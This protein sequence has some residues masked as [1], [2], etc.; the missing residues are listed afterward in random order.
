MSTEIDNELY[1]FRNELIF[2][3]F[4][5]EQ[6]KKTLG[7]CVRK[8]YKKDQFVFEEGDSSQNLYMIL[9]GY[10]NIYKWDKDHTSQLLICSIRQGKFFGEISF[11]SGLPRNASAKA[12]QPAEILVL[13]KE[14]LS[15]LPD[16]EKKMSS[17]ITG[18]RIDRIELSEKLISELEKPEVLE[19][20]A[21][22]Q[23]LSKEQLR[24]L[25]KYVIPQCFYPNE[26]IFKEKDKSTEVYLL[27]YG[28]VSV[29]KWD[30]EHSSEIFID[31]IG[32]GNIFGEM[33]FIDSSPRSATI[34]ATKPSFVI[35]LSK[36][37]LT[38]T[39]E[40]LSQLSIN[41]AKVSI[42]NVRATNIKLLENLRQN[43]NSSERSFAYGKFLLHLYLIL[44]G[45]V[46]FS[47]YAFSKNA[48]NLPWLL[49]FLPTLFMIK[50]N[51]FQWKTFGFNFQDKTPIFSTLIY[52][53]LAIGSFYIF[54]KYFGT[55]PDLVIQKNREAWSL[56][57]SRQGV[58]LAIYC[59]AQ[60]FIARGVL[61]TS[62]QNFLEDAKGYKSMVINSTFIF[63]FFFPIDHLKA[64]NLSLINILMGVIYLQQKN[65]IG[66]FVI[67]FVL[68]LWGIINV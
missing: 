15:S 68:L 37:S 16:L 64:L 25:E 32:V 18:L 56:L 50:K 29:L 47:I 33:A 51:D 48:M 11:V 14:A 30:E 63:F 54:N 5:E 12:I 46:A 45:S 2:E 55:N 35:S 10:I 39:P 24:T 34:K 23:G 67:H 53:I 65:I 44:G 43:T 26:I 42:S 8:N 36:D 58:Y 19:K 59:L 52:M 9:K 40:I 17:N 66:V 60:E 61:Q 13:S 20:Y 38:N 62:L 22:L 27:L 41:I 6:I 57:T 4:S 28:D 7:V 1:A 49:A 3:G 21:F 31:R